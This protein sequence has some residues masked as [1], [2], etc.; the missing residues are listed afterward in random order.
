MTYKYSK[1]LKFLF[2]LYREGIKLGL[3]HTYQLLNYFGN[4]H[5]NL[6][7]IH[8][9]GTN[10]KGSTCAHIESILRY[11]GYSVG[12]Y[13]SPH[14]VKFNE[15]IRVDGKLISDGEIISFM[16]K[17]SEE[18]KKIKSTFFETT[19]VMALDYFKKKKVDIA[20][21]ETGLGGRLDAT[22]VIIP[23][24]VVIASISFD[25]AEILGDSIEAIAEEK[26]GII[27]E[28]SPVIITKQDKTIMDIFKKQVSK[29]DT[30]MIVAS[31]PNN[32]KI[33]LDGTHFNLN[34]EKY[35][36]PLIGEYQAENSALAIT[37]LKEL[38]S[39]FTYDVIFQ[40]MKRVFW[41]G[42]MQRISE[43]IFYDVGHN[44]DGIK[45]TLEALRKIYPKYYIYGL[46]CIKKEKD[47][48]NIYI[49][50]QNF[51]KLYVCQDKN[52]LLVNV[53]KLSKKLKSFSL[54]NNPVDSVKSGSKILQ[55]LVDKKSI[56]LIFGSHYIAY[57]VFDTFEISF[58]YYN[59]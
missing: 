45:R 58:D 56:G 16:D 4:P 19:T 21:I 7:I 1:T 42:R 36:T 34:G 22:N 6:K 11:S 48:D 38:N 49:L 52:K 55:K 24:I 59:I 51:K 54:D 28:G 2:S 50:L 5:L 9:A 8:I 41:P 15:R 46:F 43:N 26:A 20:V 35:V 13:T 33:D 32:I 37:A 31:V 29:K 40:G 25:H 3:E 30:S 23:S 18:I 39:S 47:L 57:E 17:A 53:E 44:Y 27:K 10:G 14:L 12:V